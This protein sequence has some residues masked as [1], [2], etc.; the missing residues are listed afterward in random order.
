[1]LKRLTNSVRKRNLVWFCI[2]R[3]RKVETAQRKDIKE[4]KKENQVVDLK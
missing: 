1:M 2:Y 3:K 4:D